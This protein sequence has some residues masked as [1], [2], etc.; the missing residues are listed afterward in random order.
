MH[1]IMLSITLIITMIRKKNCFRITFYFF[2]EKKRKKIYVFL[3]PLLSIL[4][5]FCFR[6]FSFPIFSLYLALL[7]FHLPIFF[8]FQYLVYV[9]FLVISISRSNTLLLIVLFCFRPLI[10]F[11][12]FLC[13]HFNLYMHSRFFVAFIIMRTF[14]FKCIFVL[15]MY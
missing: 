1:K 12:L 14:M 9:V 4:H 3:F 5:R 11:H 6:Y 7:F 2:E 15:I 13:R 8:S 10:F